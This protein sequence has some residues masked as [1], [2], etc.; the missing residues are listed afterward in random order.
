[1]I[2]LIIDETARILFAPESADISPRQQELLRRLSSKLQGYD[3]RDILISGHTADYG[4]PDGRR[5]LSRER[6]EAV[7]GL[8]FPGGRGGPGRLYI[9]GRGAE[10][11]VGTDAENRR[12]EILILD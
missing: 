7:A 2:R 9:R 5:Q 12:V 3:D 6:A 11:P 1:M 4:T 8:L 10:E